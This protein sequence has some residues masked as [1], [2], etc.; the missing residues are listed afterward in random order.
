MVFLSCAQDGLLLF[1]KICGKSCEKIGVLSDERDRK[2][3]QKSIRQENLKLFNKN[4]IFYKR[5]LVTT[6]KRCAN[7]GIIK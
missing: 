5:K 6:L 4:I 3:P 1:S 7:I 2:L